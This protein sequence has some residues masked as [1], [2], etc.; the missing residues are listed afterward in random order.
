M[1]ASFATA[2]IPRL[3]CKKKG[4]R[5][6]NNFQ[7][8]SMNP[9]PLHQRRVSSFC[10][11]WKG[12]KRQ[13]LKTEASFS[14]RALSTSKYVGLICI[15]KTSLHTLSRFLHSLEDLRFHVMCLF[16]Q[17]CRGSTRN[18]PKLLD[19]TLKF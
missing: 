16:A 12:I 3:L 5:P 9:A 2:V 15:I 17:A 1:S 6:V 13:T 14:R 8:K 11:W 18:Y 10:C 19:F 7:K 4:P